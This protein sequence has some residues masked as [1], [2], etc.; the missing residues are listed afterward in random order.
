M[1]AF[2]RRDIGA[3]FA[4]G[5]NGIDV[6]VI[7][8]LQVNGAAIHL[9]AVIVDHHAFAIQLPVVQL[10]ED[11][12]VG[13]MYFRHLQPE[14]HPGVFP[15]GV[16]VL[17]FAGL[18]QHVPVDVGFRFVLLTRPRVGGVQNDHISVRIADDLFD[19][20]GLVPVALDVEMPELVAAVKNN[21]VLVI[22]IERVGGNRGRFQAGFGIVPPSVL[23]DGQEGA[24]L[25][26]VIE[27]IGCLDHHVK[28]LFHPG[29]FQLFRI[30]GYPDIETGQRLD[31]E[32]PAGEDDVFVRRVVNIYL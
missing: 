23:L 19:V 3:G 21:T 11:I 20:H 27:H 9:Q 29:I 31:D 22:V 32:K 7:S 1:V 5:Q 6:I 13:A 17:A 10:T 15:F 18:Y 25:R 28:L 14:F 12:D 8:L 2:N 26:F 4:I 16:G 30:L 24:Q